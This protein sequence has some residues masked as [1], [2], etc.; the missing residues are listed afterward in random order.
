M[1]EKES[2]YGR[3]N[4]LTRK[5]AIW[6]RVTGVEGQYLGGLVKHLPVMPACISFTTVAF[7]N[8]RSHR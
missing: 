3:L 7:P 4:A 1:L 2:D 6:P 8:P 5:T